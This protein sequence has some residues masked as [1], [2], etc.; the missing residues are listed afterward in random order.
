MGVEHEHERE[1]VTRSA[2]GRISDRVSHR[3]IAGRR[4]ELLGAKGSD[5]ADLDVRLR[6]CAVAI[7]AIEQLMAR[8]HVVDHQFDAG[9]ACGDSRGEPSC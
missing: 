9:N 8:D 6:H 5:T 4:H 3:P 2:P 1:R 7:D